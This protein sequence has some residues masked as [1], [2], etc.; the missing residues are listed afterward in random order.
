VLIPVEFLVNHRSILWDDRAQEVTIYH[1]ELEMH[2]VLPAN[3]VLAETCR[4]DG[5]RWLFHNAN[6]GWLLPAPEPCAPVLA[7]G[8][9]WTTSGGVCRIVPDLALA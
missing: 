1:I 8:Q 7:G 5:N 4:D 6:T 2:D 3:G 9:S